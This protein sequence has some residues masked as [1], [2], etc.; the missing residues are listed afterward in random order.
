MKRKLNEMRKIF[1]NHIV[2]KGL[3]PTI[4]KELSK[5][6]TKTNLIKK[7]AERLNKHFSKEDIQMA[8]RYMKRCSI[9]T[10]HQ[11]NTNK[12]HDDIL[13]HNY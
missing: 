10:N 11:G 8:N 7:W 1:A 6:Q 12:N 2:D 9:I 5:K 13:P 4:Y 3:I